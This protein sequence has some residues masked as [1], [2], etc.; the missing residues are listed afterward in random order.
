MSLSISSSRLSQSSSFSSHEHDDLTRLCLD[1]HKSVPTPNP[2][3]PSRSLNW[4]PDSPDANPPRMRMVKARA[5]GS[6]S[7]LEDCAEPDEEGGIRCSGEQRAFSVQ[8]ET[9]YFRENIFPEPKQ[10]LKQCKQLQWRN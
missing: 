6:C 9:N 2:F 8:L 1:S 5:S 4:D 3:A 7:G 10:E